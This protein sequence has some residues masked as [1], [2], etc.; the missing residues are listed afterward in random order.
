M[1]RSSMAVLQRT[2]RLGSSI[3]LLLKPTATVNVR[4][5]ECRFGQTRSNYHTATYISA[6]VEEH[7]YSRSSSMWLR[8]QLRVYS[9]TT[10]T[11]LKLDASRERTKRAH[12]SPN[13]RLGPLQF[14]SPVH[15]ERIRA[16]ARGA[17]PLLDEAAARLRVLRHGGLA[18]GTARPAHDGDSRRWSS[19]ARPRGYWQRKSV[20]N[21]YTTIFV[22]NC[23]ALI[24]PLPASSARPT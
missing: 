4:A 20:G 19:M 2:Y 7:K 9:T 5:G 6:A 18:L 15:L 12:S 17:L 10:S 11:T 24:V 8:I 23:Y 14:P 22:I 3:N 13:G 21:P 16:S 1:P